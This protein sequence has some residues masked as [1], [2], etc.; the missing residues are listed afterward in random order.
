MTTYEIRDDP[1][2]L[3]IICATLA[4]AERRGQ[5]R[6]V[7]LGIDTE[8]AQEEKYAHRDQLD[9][10]EELTLTLYDFLTWIQDRL[11]MTLLAQMQ[12]DDDE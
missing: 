10:S 9:E 7:R 2:D 3:P 4:E 6:A 1:D 5:R 12:G 11:T 8:E